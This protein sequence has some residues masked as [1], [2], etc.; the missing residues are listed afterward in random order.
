MSKPPVK[1]RQ[2]DFAAGTS[3]PTAEEIQAQTEA[4][5][6]RE[7]EE[8]KRQRPKATYDLPLKMIAAVEAI[9][10]TESVARSD[11]VELALREFIQRY[12]AGAVDLRPYK[13][14]AKSLRV[15]WKL[16]LPEEP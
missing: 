14:R 7:A 9:A 3:A 1:E 6:K 12:R 11:I 13:T 5:K 10:N 2:E 16:E 15:L 4:R 8:R